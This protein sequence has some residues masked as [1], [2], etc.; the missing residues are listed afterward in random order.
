MKLYLV[1]H[2][3]AEDQP[4]ET[5]ERP[6]SDRGR[7]DI[8]AQ[9]TFLKN[10]GITVSQVFHSG[11]LRA[12]Q[13]AEII[14]AEIAPDAPMEPMQYLTPMDGTDHLALS[15]ENW[16]DSNLD[17]MVSGHNPFMEAMAARLLCGNHKEGAVIVKTGTV[18]CFERYAPGRWR[19]DW[20]VIPKL[21]R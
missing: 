7:S 20:M 17:T 3:K 6:L 11:K 8:A 12:H 15:V 2:G 21:T 14:A 19:M 18:M 10:A 5:G 4:D 13:T 16:A 9:A 1:R